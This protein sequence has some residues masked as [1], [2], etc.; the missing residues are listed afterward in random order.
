MGLVLSLQLLV[1]TTP[2]RVEGVG[3]NGPM[4]RLA[5]LVTYLL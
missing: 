1:V 2:L 5:K 3:P 4:S